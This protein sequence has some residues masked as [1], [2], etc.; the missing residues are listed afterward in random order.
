MACGEEGAG[1]LCPQPCL[2]GPRL[3]DAAVLGALR[4]KRRQRCEQRWLAL[5][6]PSLTPKGECVCL[7]IPHT[8]GLTLTSSLGFRQEEQGTRGAARR[9][10]PLPWVALPCCSVSSVLL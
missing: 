10:T 2:A 7:P 5:P 4:E 6:L 9:G 8:L 1:G 3:H